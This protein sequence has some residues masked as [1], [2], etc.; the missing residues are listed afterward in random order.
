MEIGHTMSLS[1]SSSA[2]RVNLVVAYNAI[3][4]QS[5]ERSYYDCR[6]PLL[7]V[8]FKLRQEDLACRS[9][10]T[11]GYSSPYYF[12]NRMYHLPKEQQTPLLRMPCSVM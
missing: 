4:N 6:D 1:L 10:Y 5:E 12:Y 7:N 2:S 11:L 3:H 8:V 9:I